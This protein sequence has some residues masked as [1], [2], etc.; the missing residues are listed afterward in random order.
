MKDRRTNDNADHA[1]AP[2][3]VSAGEH[4]PPPGVLLFP[5]IPGRV[6]SIPGCRFPLE[7]QIQEM[8]CSLSTEEGLYVHPWIPPRRL[9]EA[10]HL[11]RVPQNEVVLGL[12]DCSASTPGPSPQ[13]CLFGATGVYYHNDDRSMRPGTRQVTYGDLARR[14]I[15]NKVRNHV[16][17]GGLDYLY[18]P[19]AGPSRK[20]VATCFRWLRILIRTN[21]GSI[22]STGSETGPVKESAPAKPAVSPEDLRLWSRLKGYASVIMLLLLALAASGLELSGA[23]GWAL[24]VN[25][26]AAGV[27]LHVQAL[28]LLGRREDK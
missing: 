1:A 5:S 20:R 10:R 17:L 24:L 26:C 19:A 22:Q 14:Q 9:R 4:P 21:Q 28:E 25:G 16:H 18:V 3:E 15:D 11:C 8:L 6:T 23:S 7:T 2:A 12:L 27:L 13:V